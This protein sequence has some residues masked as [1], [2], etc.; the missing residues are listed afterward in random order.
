MHVLIAIVSTFII[1]ATWQLIATR[2]IRANQRFMTVVL[3]KELNEMA[4][5][6]GQKDYIS[7]L[8][9]TKGEEYA[10]TAAINLKS[11]YDS[12]SNRGAD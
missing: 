10:N 11:F 6:L 5:K 2:K 12:F 7:Y 8:R 4:T 3:I 1:A 9:A